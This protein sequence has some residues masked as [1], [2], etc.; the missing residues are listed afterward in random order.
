V[1]LYVGAMSRHRQGDIRRAVPFVVGAVLVWAV[2]VGVVF[3]QRRGCGAAGVILGRESRSAK[4]VGGV[5]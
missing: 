4:W 2:V 1:L 3:G 5:D